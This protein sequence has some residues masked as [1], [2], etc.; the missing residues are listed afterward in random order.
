MGRIEKVG[1]LVQPRTGNWLENK[2]QEIKSHNQRQSFRGYL[3]GLVVFPASIGEGR[4]ASR[5]RERN[6]ARR[7]N[8]KN[9]FGRIGGERC[10]KEILSKPRDR[11]GGKVRRSRQKKSRKEGEHLVSL[12]V[13]GQLSDSGLDAGD[14]R[15]DG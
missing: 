14:T 5:G 8:T 12:H 11:I 10:G 7:A 1:Y 2:T 3:V 9:W 15:F 4:D 13:A 6:R